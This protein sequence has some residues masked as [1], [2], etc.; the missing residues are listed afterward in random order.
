MTFRN[1]HLAWRLQLEIGVTHFAID[2][3]LLSASR[4]PPSEQSDVILGKR[5]T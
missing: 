3:E 4:L 2:A 5:A 1:H